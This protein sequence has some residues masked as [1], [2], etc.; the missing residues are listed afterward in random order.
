MGFQPHWYR[1]SL[2]LL[3]ALGSLRT[4]LLDRGKRP[5]G[6]PLKWELNKLPLPQVQDTC[7]GGSWICCGG[8][9]VPVC[10]PPHAFCSDH[11]RGMK[12]IFSLWLFCLDQCVIKGA[13][14]RTEATRFPCPAASCSCVKI[15]GMG[16][17]TCCWCGVVGKRVAENCRALS[18]TGE[19]QRSREKDVNK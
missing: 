13:A 19:E 4:V 12:G 18:L 9:E 2:K 8:A 11:L 17:T 7:D 14:W 3:P 1:V 5:R 6:R 10:N 16:D 15:P